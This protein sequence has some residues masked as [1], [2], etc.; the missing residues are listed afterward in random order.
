MAETKTDIGEPFVETPR[1][2]SEIAVKEEAAETA[3][4]TEKT[5]H[6]A[7]RRTKRK[8]PKTK[9][10]TVPYDCAICGKHFKQWSN[11]KTHEKV[12]TRERPYSSSNLQR[13]VRIHTGEKPFEC[14]ICDNGFKSSSD[15]KVKVDLNRAVSSREARDA[16]GKHL[17][18][19]WIAAFHEETREFVQVLFKFSE[20]QVVHGCREH[21]VGFTEDRS[22]KQ[23]CK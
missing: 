2:E 13:H 9:K 19:L 10:A 7:N 15:L 12:H 22:T 18:L 8:S 14:R 1:S 23:G 20:G 16:A 11:L 3:D 6:Q 17:S 4:E 5:G 21:R